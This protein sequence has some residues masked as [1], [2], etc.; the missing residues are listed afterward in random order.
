MVYDWR[1]GFDIP[2]SEEKQTVLD[3]RADLRTLSENDENG[4]SM[5]YNEI[6]SREGYEDQASFEIMQKVGM[7]KKDIKK[8]INSQML[9]VFFLP[10]AVA[11]L[12]LCFAFPFLSKILLLFASNNTPLNIGVSVGC[13][14]LFGALYAVVYKITSGAYYSIVSKKKNS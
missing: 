2:K 10:L 5:Y 4:M 6:Y 9:T 8:S 7:T 11:G 12:H 3:L 14:L 13:F 1:C